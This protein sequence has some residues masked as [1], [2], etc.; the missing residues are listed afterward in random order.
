ML[1]QGECLLHLDDEVSL[2]VSRNYRSPVKTSWD[3]AKQALSTC[4]APSPY[5]RVCIKRS[6]S[7]WDKADC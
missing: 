4:L 1:F 6:A 7:L 3:K 5:R 2:K